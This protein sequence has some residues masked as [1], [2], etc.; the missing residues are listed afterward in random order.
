MMKNN[1]YAIIGN[2]GEYT[3]F[4]YKDITITFL[5]GKNLEKYASVKEWDNGYI[6]V[7]C[8]NK[9]SSELEEDYIDLLPILKNLKM[10]P[11]KFLNPIKEVRVYAD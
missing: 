8:K 9:N 11:E 6:V 10:D 1:D 4:T 5:T 2:S 3:F 7:M